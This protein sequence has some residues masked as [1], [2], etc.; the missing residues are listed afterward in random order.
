MKGFIEYL[1]ESIQEVEKE[2]ENDWNAQ[3]KA[4]KESREYF[5]LSIY[6]SEPELELV[7]DS[8]IEYYL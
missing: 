7:S 6:E 8:M 2:L 5:D 1:I 4:E 3:I